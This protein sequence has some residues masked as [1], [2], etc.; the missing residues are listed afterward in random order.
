[1]FIERGDIAAKIQPDP[2]RFLICAD[3]FQTGYDEPLLHTMYVDKPM[4][5]HGLM[6]AIASGPDPERA[7]N[8]LSDIVE[9]LSSGVNFYRLLEARPQLAALVAQILTHAPALAD[10]LARRPTLLAGKA[11][12]L[13][14]AC[15]AATWNELLAEHDA[16][17]QSISKLWNSIRQGA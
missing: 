14:D 9:R 11:D 7:L 10:Q 5:S 13:A 12:E 17:R 15:G 1:M 6:Q 3:K 16:A 2:Y 4:R 8:R